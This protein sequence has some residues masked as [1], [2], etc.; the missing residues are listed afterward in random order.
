MLFIL[1][2]MKSS[3]DP[4]F[5]AFSKFLESIDSKDECQT[6]RNPT[7]S[8]EVFCS[9]PGFSVYI[10]RNLFFKFHFQGMKA[11]YPHDNATRLDI[12]IES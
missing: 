9:Y 12:P 8:L 2:V 4:N 7:K 5:C 3:L 11:S 1:I 6:K 10:H